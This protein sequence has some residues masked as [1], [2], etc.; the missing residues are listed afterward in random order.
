ME[1]RCYNGGEGRTRLR[2]LK[3]TARDVIALVIT[4]VFYA[5]AI[6][7]SILYKQLMK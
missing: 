2:Q 4:L 3:A 1:C 7:V 5:A 6:T